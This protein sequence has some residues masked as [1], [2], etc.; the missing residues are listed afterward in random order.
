[1]KKYI[2]IVMLCLCLG[3]QYT[4]FASSP[5]T[6][7]FALHYAVAANNLV[8]GERT[9]KDETWT[10]ACL[11]EVHRIY[12]YTVNTLIQQFSDCCCENAYTECC[13]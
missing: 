10:G 7:R 5:C 2:S 1:M 8:V 6:T 3:M 13:N 12:K 4:V 11:D 9:C